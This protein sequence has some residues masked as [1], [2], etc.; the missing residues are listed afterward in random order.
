MEMGEDSLKTKRHF[1]QVLVFLILVFLIL[2]LLSAMVNPGEVPVYNVVKVTKKLEALGGEKPGTLEVLFA[3]NSLACNGFSPLMLYEDYGFTSY[4][5]AEESQR[6]CDNVAVL[7]E[8][9]K[10]Q[11][12]KV[13]VL[14]ADTV[15]SD[16]SPYRVNYALPT[17]ALE[18][19]FPIF[20]YHIFYKGVL[21]NHKGEEE[22]FNKGFLPVK[23][24]VP[25]KEGLDPMGDGAG[26]VSLEYDSAQFMAKLSRICKDHGIDL[27]IAALPCPE[28]WNRGK[29]E[30]AKAWAEE[31][32]AYFLDMNENTEEMGINWEEDLSDG[33]SH[34]NVSGA[35]KATD[36][37]G[38]YLS[39]RFAL[40]DHRGDPVGESFLKSAGRE[41]DG[42]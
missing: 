39:D 19:L 15:F 31:N 30:T 28:Y 26:P 33:G 27:V 18:K 38:R 25:L 40:T 16:A 11:D 3:G 37:I 23:D 32:G 20:H 35:G 21:E 13:C 34:L 24:A 41:G 6:L 29:H 8:T 9:I 10:H 1:L 2:G 7:E 42:S 36:A 14:E 4:V 22:R 17:N 12:I 5:I